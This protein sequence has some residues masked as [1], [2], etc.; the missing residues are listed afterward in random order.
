LSFRVW[1]DLVND[2]GVAPD[3]YVRIVVSAALRTLGAAHA[4]TTEPAA[5]PRSRAGGR[6][7]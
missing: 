2:L 7:R 1:D 4:S 3:T 5:R 6:R